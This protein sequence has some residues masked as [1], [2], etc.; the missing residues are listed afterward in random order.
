MTTKTRNIIGWVLT[1]LLAV[2]FLGSASMKFN[3][4][5]ETLRHLTDLGFTASGLK[6]VGVL[7]IFCFVMF[8]IPRTGVLG[9]LLLV[10]YMGGAIVTHIEHQ[11]PAMG[12]VIV[13]CLV[14]ITAAIRFPELSQR[15]LGKQDKQV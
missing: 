13:S 8:V 9:T 6:L 11:Q 3:P 2:A 15:L 14:W 5:P 12:P 4:N 1:V 10:A 7:E